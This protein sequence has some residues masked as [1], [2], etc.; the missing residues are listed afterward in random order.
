MDN[1]N[2]NND[3]Q[4]KKFIRI[5]RKKPLLETYT[6]K[7]CKKQMKTADVKP[8]HYNTKTCFTC[9]NLSCKFSNN[10]NILLR[11]LKNLK[12]DDKTIEKLLEDEWEHVF[13]KILNKQEDTNG[14]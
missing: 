10:K 9:Y 4:P 6:C 2:N 11:H 13:K 3:L 8:R 12:V 1:N 5:G 7:Y 14:D